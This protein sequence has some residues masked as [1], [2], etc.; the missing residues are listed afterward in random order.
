MKKLVIRSTDIEALEQKKYEKLL[1]GWKIKRPIKKI[2]FFWWN[3]ILE[4]DG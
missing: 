1:E 3:V 4:K 2:L